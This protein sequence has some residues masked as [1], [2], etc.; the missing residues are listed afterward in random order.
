MI[1][2]HKHSFSAELYKRKGAGTKVSAPLGLSILIKD[3]CGVSLTTISPL[4]IACSAS[5]TASNTS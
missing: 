2:S 5:C 1:Q 3:Y 4:I